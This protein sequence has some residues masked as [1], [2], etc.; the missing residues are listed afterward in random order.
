MN[1]RVFKTFCQEMEAEYE[2][3]LYDTEFRRFEAPEAFSELW[4]EV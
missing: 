1:H 2:V 4:A 3:L